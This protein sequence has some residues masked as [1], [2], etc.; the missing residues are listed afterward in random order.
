MSTVVYLVG[1]ITL[2]AWALTLF[3]ALRDRMPK[4]AATTAT[5]LTLA[6]IGG[7]GF[8]GLRLAACSFVE[9]GEVSQGAAEIWTRLQEGP[10]FVVLMPL[11]VMAILGSLLAGIAMIRARSEVTVWAGPLYLAGFVLGSG[12]FPVPVSV[13]GGLLQAVA[14]LLV[15]RL[16]VRR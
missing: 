3:A 2:V 1:M 8:A 6:A 7:S 13:V 10:A 12:E 15:A 9:D 14:V 5:M 11:M 4:L 16:A